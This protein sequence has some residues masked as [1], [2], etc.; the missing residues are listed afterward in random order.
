MDWILESGVVGLSVGDSLFDVV[1]NEGREGLEGSVEE[2][3]NEEA[4]EGEGEDEISLDGKEESTG[5]WSGW[6]LIVR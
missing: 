5:S 2:E 3:M 1:G 6:F 4:D